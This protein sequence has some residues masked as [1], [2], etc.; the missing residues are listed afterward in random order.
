MK[1]AYLLVAHHQ[2]EHL[3]R[4]IKSLDCDWACFFIHI[5]LKSDIN[6]FKY[7]VPDQENIIFLEGGDRYS[8]NWGGFSVVQAVLSLLS[9][10]YAA[11]S[12]FQRFCL[13][14]GSDYPVKPLKTIHDMFSTDIEFM[15]VERILSTESWNSHAGFV[16]YHHFID[17]NSQQ[18]R[19]KSGKIQRDLYDGFPLY[20]GSAWWSLTGNCVEYIIDF[21]ESNPD[22]TEFHKTTFCPDE[23][24]F[25]SIVKNSPFCHRLIHD[26][27]TRN[28]FTEFSLLNEHGCHYIDWNSKNTKLPKVLDL[29]DYYFLLKTE[30]LFARK[31]ESGKSSSILS[32]I[33]DYIGEREQSSEENKTLVIF[34]THI[35]NEDIISE[36]ERIKTAS[37]K[38]TSVVL[39]YDNTPSDFDA[40]WFQSEGDYFLFD[41]ETVF[42]FFGIDFN[43]GYLYGNANLPL[44]YYFS[45]YPEYQYY[46]LIEYDVRFTGDWPSFFNS[47]KAS[48]S[49]LLGTTLYSYQYC[50][51]WTYWESLKPPHRQIDRD[52]M[53]RGFFPIV[54]YSKRACERLVNAYLEGWRGH[55]EVLVPTV[56]SMQGFSIEDIG[57]DCEFTPAERRNHFYQNTP[58]NEALAPG[59]FRFQPSHSLPLELPDMLYH[60]IKPAKYVDKRFLKEDS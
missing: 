23:I 43:E 38:Q 28:D 31:F 5:D 16:S 20:H 53:I 39:F 2:P 25:Q 56:L 30:M 42:S 54:R 36:F 4:L 7:Y 58:K 45:R 55:F 49:D 47:F 37:G 35:L 60:P 40:S 22:Y 41:T 48:E 21:L 17:S 24:Y 59:T 18:D 57:G 12:Q 11:D 9:E 3:A 15:S 46:W 51:D 29:G 27:E 6:I 44:L 1:V 33:D 52:K 8:V 10:T 26:Y 32:A 14:S 19:D 50:T 13:L 34:Q